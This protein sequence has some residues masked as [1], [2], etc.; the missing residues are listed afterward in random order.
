MAPSA[1]VDSI[2]F[3]ANDHVKTDQASLFFHK[4]SQVTD[5]GGLNLPRTD[6]VMHEIDIAKQPATT[7]YIATRR[8]HKILKKADP[9]RVCIRAAVAD[10]AVN[11]RACEQWNRRK[12]VPIQFM[13]NCHEL[14]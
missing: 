3:D 7:Y 6:A 10:A 9:N 14:Y 1:E 12:R 5:R 11:R 2:P 13:T 4:V 8:Y